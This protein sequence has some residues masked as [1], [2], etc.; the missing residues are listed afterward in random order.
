M[1]DRKQIVALMAT[2]G[3]LCPLKG[4]QARDARLAYCRTVLRRPI[5]SCND[6]T[7]AETDQVI[8]AMQRELASRPASR[9][10]NLRQFPN[11][12][13]PSREMVWKIRQLES[14]LGWTPVP[15]RLGGFLRHMFRKS[16]PE[17]LTHAQAWRA[18]EALHD[19]AARAQIKADKGAAYPVSKPELAA[20]V[21]T[22]KVTLASWRPQFDTPEQKANTR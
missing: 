12:N 6:L 8:S 9:P 5:E 21:A 11:R 17:Q 15:E 13:T 1:A 7:P 20:A 22:L 2:W 3:N 14:W 4:E 18:V 10:S 19:V 16:S